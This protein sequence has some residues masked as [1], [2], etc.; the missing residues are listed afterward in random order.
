MNAC[1]ADACDHVGSAYRRDPVLQE[2]ERTFVGMKRD[3]MRNIVYLKVWQIPPVHASHK[4]ATA[5]GGCATIS[6]EPQEYFVLSL[7]LV[8]ATATSAEA[9]LSVLASV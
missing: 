7:C 2:A 1:A 4:T 5:E 9:L 8:K 6:I 3:K